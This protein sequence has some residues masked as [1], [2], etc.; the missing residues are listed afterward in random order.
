MAEHDYVIDNQNA[1]SFRADLN[2]ALLAIVSNNSKSTEPTVTYADMIWY[3]TAAKILK[4]RSNADDAWINVAYVDQSANAWRVL[5]D[6]QVVNTS[7]TQTGLIG[8]Q[9]TAT[10][11]AG[12]GTTESL[13]SPAKVKAAIDASAAPAAPSVIVEGYNTGTGLLAATTWTDCRFSSLV[14]NTISATLASHRVTLPAG[15]YYIDNFLKMEPGSGGV[16]RISLRLYDHTN[17]AIIAEYVINQGQL[18]HSAGSFCGA[19]VFTLS[20]PAAIAL[21]VYKDSG[22]GAAL[23]ALVKIW[24]TA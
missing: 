3:D 13:V 4:M 8:D 19:N 24:K 10:W 7:G 6:T 21:Q 12:T 17:T 5:D 15:T 18:D 22:A 20:A 2:N 23:N 16:V 9:S 11:E 14:Q 1:P